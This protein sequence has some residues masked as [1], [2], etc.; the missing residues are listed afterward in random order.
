MLALFVLIGEVVNLRAVLVNVSPDLFALLTFN[1][2]LI[3]GILVLLGVSL[4]TG[5]IAAGISLLPNRYRGALSQAVIVVVILGL[6]RDLIVTVI[7]RWGVVQYAFLWMFR[8]K[9]PEDHRCSGCICTRWCDLPTGAKARTGRQLLSNE[10][11]ASE[12]QFDGEQ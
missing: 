8:F 4:V 7:L 6:F 11:R 1:L 5:L 3:P 10:V 9:R 2:P 12:A